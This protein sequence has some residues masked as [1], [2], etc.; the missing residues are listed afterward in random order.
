MAGPEGG[1]VGAADGVGNAGVM[2]AGGNAG[3][4]VGFGNSTGEAAGG[5]VG[6]SVGNPAGF[7][8][9]IGAGGVTGEAAPGGGRAGALLLVVGGGVGTGVA[10]TVTAGPLGGGN[11]GVPC[12]QTNVAK[13]TMLRPSNATAAARKLHFICILPCPDLNS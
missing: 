11:G 13:L 5:G 1:A 9:S 3:V 6:K 10:G 8:N 7:G 2:L 12:P 4:S